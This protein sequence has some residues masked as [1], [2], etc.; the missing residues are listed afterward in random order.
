MDQSK[1][2]ENQSF[3]SSFLSHRPPRIRFSESVRA[4]VA[5]QEQN[6]A[7]H[8]EFMV[9]LM[10]VHPLIPFEQYTF[11]SDEWDMRR[12]IAYE[13]LLRQLAHVRSF[14]VNA[15]I[16]NGPGMGTALRCML[17]IHAF[18]NYLLADGR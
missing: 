2:A 11:G 18:C 12:A 17:E 16:G 1:L 8:L 5:S 15:N 7:E 14:V 3:Q 9:S 4:K 10:E 13:I 6:P